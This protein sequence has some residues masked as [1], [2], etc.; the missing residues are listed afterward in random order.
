MENIFKKKGESSSSSISEIIDSKRGG[1]L[2]CLKSLTSEQLSVINLLTGSK[3]C[4]NLHGT[5]II[6]F[7]PWIWD[8][9]SWKKSALVRS[10]ILGLFLNT[11]TAK[12]T[13]SRRNMETLTQQVQTPLSLK[14]KTF[15]GF[16]IA[17]L[18]STWNGEHFQKKGESSS[19]SI[20]EII[21]SK[22]GGYL[23]AWKA[24]PQQLSVINL[25]TGSK[26]CLNMQG[27]TIILFFQESGLNWAG[28]SLP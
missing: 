15:S 16:V 4:L 2:K 13:Y 24:L 19:L 3:H 27:I 23:S 14:Q 8:K 9:L 26:H 21:D 5:T 11:L 1:L 20:S 7:F 18:K 28:K 22:R 10:K 25:L 6:L 12:Y 17:F